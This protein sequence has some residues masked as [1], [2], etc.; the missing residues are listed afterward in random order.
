MLLTE[1]SPQAKYSPASES[2]NLSYKYYEINNDPVQ[3]EFISENGKEVVVI[4][5]TDGISTT[6][7][8]NTIRNLR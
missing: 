2:K 4:P 5:R 1:V 6:S 8:K 3:I 7:L